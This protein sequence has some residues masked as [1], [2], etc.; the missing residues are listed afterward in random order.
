MS[1]APINFYFVKTAIPHGKHQFLQLMAKR[2]NGNLRSS[3]NLFTL[4]KFF[5]ALHIGTEMFRLKQLD[6]Q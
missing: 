5:I 1:V 2:P 4:C 3:F 6:L